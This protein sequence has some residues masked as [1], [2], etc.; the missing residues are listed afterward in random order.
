MIR[1]VKALKILKL[2]EQL[3]PEFEH[4]IGLKCTEPINCGQ[5]LMCRACIGDN[6]MKYLLEEYRRL[7]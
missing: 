1:I 6:A 2:V 4:A 7:I 5:G 3:I